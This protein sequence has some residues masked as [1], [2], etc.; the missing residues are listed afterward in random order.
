MAV[1]DFVVKDGSSA[2][3]ATVYV[4]VDD[5]AYQVYLRTEKPDTDPVKYEFET[6]TAVPNKP[7]SSD[8][9]QHHYNDEAILVSVTGGTITS[10]KRGKTDIPWSTEATAERRS[11][12][13]ADQVTNQVTL[14]SL[15]EETKN[16]E[17]DTDRTLSSSITLTGR[18][19]GVRHVY[20]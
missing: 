13:D 7:I 9:E 14:Y 6:L 5:K 11:A 1:G 17:L 3:S 12:V 2:S 18:V 19:G 10:L 16:R 20:D 4:E 8:S 15:I